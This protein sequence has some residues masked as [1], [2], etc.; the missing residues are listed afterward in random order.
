M[1][2]MFM[3][4]GCAAGLLL[5]TRA[6]AQE[7]TTVAEA[8]RRATSVE[9]PSPV[10]PVEMTVAESLVKSLSSGAHI[11]ELPPPDAH[12]AGSFRVRVV[13]EGEDT[14][15]GWFRFSLA[16]DGTGELVASRPHLLY[17]ALC[18]VLEERGTDDVRLYAKGRTDSVRLRWLEGNDGLFTGVPR[19]IRNYDPELTIREMARL[20]CSHVSVNVL[21]ATA[22]AEQGVPGEIYPRFYVYSPDI[23]QFV[24]SDLTRGLYPPEYLQANLDLLK[25]NAALAVA[26]GLTPGLTVCSPRT[27]PEPFFTKY[28]YLRGARVDHPFRS[29]NPRYTATLSHPLVRWHYAQLMRTMMREVPQ[30]GFLYLW[31]NDSGSGFEY[32][33]TLYA[34]R[35]GGAYLIREWKS[36]EA[37]ARAAG[38]NVIR[39]LRLLRDAASETNPRFRVITSLTWFGA[40]KDVIL[41]GL[42][43][44]LDLQVQPADTV[45]TRRWTA[46]LAR[47]RRGTALFGTLRAAPNYVLGAPC[48]WL[49]FDRLT[50]AASTAVPNLSVTFD[51]P[52]LAPW[53]VNREIIRAYQRGGGE[54]VDAIVMGV[55]R[56]WCG[57]DAAPRLVRAWRLADGA[58]R[59]FPDVPLYGNSWAFPWYRH[60][61]RPFVPDIAAIPADERAYYERHMIATFNNPT[62]VDFGADALWLLIDRGQA[63]SILRTCD[64]L[65]WEPLDD[66]IRVLDTLAG[67]EMREGRRGGVLRDQRDRLVA[68]RCYYRTLRNVAGWIAGVHGYVEAGSPAERKRMLFAVREMIDDEVKNTGELYRLWNTTQTEFMPVATQGES[69]ALYGENFG[70]LL[71]KKIALMNQHRDDT[72]AIDAD[73]MWKVGPESPVKAGE[74][75]RY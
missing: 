66:A 42:G 27:M 29:Y 74:Y 57:A 53:S 38:E 40:E 63:A 62:L 51:P 31:T 1:R 7:K 21:A 20:G 13:R 16:P 15:A 72:P 44:R 33:S 18:T 56:R 48:P 11:I 37:V 47:G 2:N 58:V 30:L 5:S 41:D 65:V 67:G 25:K 59:S 9:I 49:T 54:S 3:A 23:D 71:R 39:Y 36:D 19:F 4:L 6:P 45:D 75:L 35:N 10:F 70:D 50:A 34:G 8:L 28:P 14:S 68:L 24:E 61:V 12:R 73:F 69:W 43:E 52:S 60:W 46:V 26:Y 32:V 22:A 55:A 17:G 64:S